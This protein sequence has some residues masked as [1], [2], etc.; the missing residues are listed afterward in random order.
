MIVFDRVG[1]RKGATFFELQD[2]KVTKLVAYSERDQAIAAND[3]PRPMQTL[4]TL[5]AYR[6]PQA[7]EQDT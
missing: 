3:P 1:E 7:T 5:L 2:Q 4:L 6:R